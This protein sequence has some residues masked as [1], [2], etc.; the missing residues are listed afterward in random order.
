[1][2]LSR[3]LVH[4]TRSLRTVAVAARPALTLA[5]SLARLSIPATCISAPVRTLYSSPT[6]L[7]KKKKMPPKKKVVDD[8]KIILGRPG[9]NLKVCRSSSL[10][11][12]VLTLARLVLS[13]SPTSASHRSSTPSRR[14]TSARLPTSPTPPCEWRALSSQQKC[15]TDYPVTPRRP[16]SPS[17]M[18][19]STGSARCTSP[20]PRSPLSL[21]AL[22][23]PV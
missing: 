13:V 23:L 16:V 12:C 19:A 10:V 22:T 18:S 9:N 11:I 6:L 14:P 21:P 17:P 15:T 1:M 4:S 8:K 5:P 3:Q 20:S 2:H 7:S